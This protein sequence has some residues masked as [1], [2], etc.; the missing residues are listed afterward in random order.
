MVRR[1]SRSSRSSLSAAHVVAAVLVALGASCLPELRVFPA[2]RPTAR[3][4]DGFVEPAVN[5]VF[6]E[7]CDPGELGA[8]GCSA[9][10]EIVCNDGRSKEESGIRSE[11][12][13]CY[14][15]S[16]S[17]SSF[18]EASQQCR[19]ASAHLVTFA[20]ELEVRAV[21]EAVVLSREF[22]VGLTHDVVVGGYVTEG[23]DEPGYPVP[24]ETGLCSGCYGR[25]GGGSSFPNYT[26][27]AGDPACLVAS[28]GLKAPWKRVPCVRAPLAFDVLCEREPPGSRSEIC[29][30]GVCVHLQHTPSKRYLFVPTAASVKEAR[31]TC[32]ALGGHLVLLS[33]AEEREELARE[34]ARFLPD[35]TSAWVGLSRRIPGG[36]FLW[37]DEKDEEGKRPLFWGNDEP[38]ATGAAQAFIDL[39]RGVYDVRLLRAQNEE[40][41]RPYVCQY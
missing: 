22:W 7:T 13:H 40:P 2:S 9:K 41:P 33:S 17:T 29:N 12:G 25:N 8:R 20:N 24:R 36:P 3:C 31:E 38:R 19:A 11:T 5:G 39:G 21:T 15:V 16:G 37:D 1:S 10:C 34:I 4:G 35:V 18:T 28:P 23:R 26:D 6:T 27:V 32:S 30:G 14:F